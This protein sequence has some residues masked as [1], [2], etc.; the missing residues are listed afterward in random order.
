MQHTDRDWR[1]LAHS[2]VPQAHRGPAA[3]GSHWHDQ[4]PPAGSFGDP[5]EDRASGWEAAWIDLGGE[6]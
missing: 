5:I 3:V 4:P 2:V 1:P 6:G